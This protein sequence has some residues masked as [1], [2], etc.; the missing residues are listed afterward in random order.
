MTKLAL[1]TGASS[2]IGKALARTHVEQSGGD[3]IITARRTEL[4]EALKAE[5]EKAHGVKVHVIT[6]DLSKMDGAQK[7][8]DEVRKRKL[9]VDYLINNAGVGG[10]GDLLERDLKED[11]DMIVL[12]V[13]SYVALTH[14]FAKQMV[15]RGGG[16]ILMVS[17]FAS[18]IPGPNRAVYHATKAFI[19][20]F[21][22]A[23]DQELEKKG[24]TCTALCPGFVDLTEASDKDMNGIKTSKTIVDGPTRVARLGYDA[25]IRDKLMVINEYKLSFFTNWVIPFVPRRWLL[26]FVD[27]NHRH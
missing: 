10:N 14:L 22:Q 15:E 9:Q 4:L 23:I 6:S 5:L 24:V 1:V 12:N 3:L 21:S 16:K 17:S 19:T 7:L 27:Y 2:G 20:S 13:I 11:I 25:M 26:A 8:Y 18:F